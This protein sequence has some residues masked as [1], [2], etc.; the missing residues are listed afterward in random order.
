MAMATNTVVYQVLDTVVRYPV[1]QK[2]KEPRGSS[3]ERA[4]A[5]RPTR[6]AARVCAGCLRVYRGPYTALEFLH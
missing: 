6:Q 5:Q 2:R 4:T 1:T 3:D